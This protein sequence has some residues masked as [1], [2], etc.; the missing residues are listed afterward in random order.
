MSASFQIAANALS[1]WVATLVSGVLG[2]LLIPI[3]LSELGREG[4]G[5]LALTGTF[6]AFT[7]IADLMLREALARQLALELAR[8]GVQEFRQWVASARGLYAFLG[9][10][11]AL[12][13]AIS[14]PS[15]AVAFKVSARCWPEAVLLLRWYAP[16]AVL[17]T[18]W[19]SL[20]SAVLASDNR[21]D[22]VNLVSSISYAVR[23][24]LLLVVL[25]ATHAGLPGWVAVTLVTEMGRVTI[26]RQAAFRFQPGLARRETGFN[27][28]GAVRLARTG[29]A[30]FVAQSARL[31]LLQVSQFF[32][33]ARFGPAVLALYTP[34]LQLFNSLNPFVYALATQM[35]PLTTRLYATEDKA[36]LTQALTT[37]TKYT[38]LQ[39]VGVVAFLAGFSDS[40]IN[41][42]LGAKLEGAAVAILSNV[43]LGLALVELT[44]F[45]TGTQWAVLLGM[46][47]LKVY[48]I[49][50]PMAISVFLVSAPLLIQHTRLG[51]YGVVVSNLV[52]S[53][54][55]RAVS[56]M[57][58]ARVCGLGMRDYFAQSYFRPMCI[59]LALS[60]WALALNRI[61]RPATY[62]SLGSCGAVVFVCWAALCWV[63]G[64]SATDR[65]RVVALC[66]Q[67]AVL[68]RTDWAHRFAELPNPTSSSRLPPRQGL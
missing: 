48:L 58:T 2:W 49:T 18:F 36:K 6:I 32:L 4:Y 60:A 66:R 45:A 17:L 68:L 38:L 41:I 20:Y 21:F 11:I 43:L 9:G 50:A 26:L 27:L 19:G 30:Y 47:R 1:S 54:C 14:A 25:K 53:I 62:A 59:L 37:G 35:S 24:A 10:A 13:L 33:S 7:A 5:L 15:L 61:C 8:G 64:F 56:A 40:I 55:I 31:V 42:W 65:S 28:Q 63:F 57:Y 12:V 51:L 52:I 44:G 23:A 46:N 16:L 39:G 3:Y 67:G 34:V 29:L 22:K